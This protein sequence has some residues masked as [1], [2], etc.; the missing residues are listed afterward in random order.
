[1][2]YVSSI[3]ISMCAGIIGLIFTISGAVAIPTAVTAYYSK[4][5]F[6]TPD[7]ILSNK[8]SGCA[9]AAVGVVLFVLGIILLLAVLLPSL[10]R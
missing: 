4:S 9:V 8:A 1:M 6:D 2:E 3:A 5:T 7:D 10:V